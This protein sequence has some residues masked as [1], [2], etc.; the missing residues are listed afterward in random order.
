MIVV[1]IL[2]WFVLR[3]RVCADVGFVLTLGFESS[4]VGII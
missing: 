2:G 3:F 4:G 1:W